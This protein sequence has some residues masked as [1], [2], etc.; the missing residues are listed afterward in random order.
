MRILCDRI[1]FDLDGV[2]A[3]S[4]VVV[5]RH[6]RFWAERRGIAF[7]RVLEVHHGRRT[8]ETISL[9][10]PEL[11]SEAEAAEIEH[12]AADDT[13]GVVAFPGARR[14]L[15]TIPGDRWAI[16]TSGTRRIAT[17][18]IAHLGFPEPRVFVAAEDVTVGKPAP[19]PYLLAAARLGVEARRCLV[20]EDAPAGVEAGLAAGA[21]VVGIA[22]TLPAATLSR[23]TVVIP[24]L[25]DLAVAVRSGQLEVTWTRPEGT[26]PRSVVR[27]PA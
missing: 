9:L 14:L 2:L 24:R 8:V 7:E 18:R 12:V 5:E 22:S 6:L 1:I 17:N 26:N 16:A 10:A 15:E 4:N 13:D 20:V 23:A 19:D 11:D 25:D 3:D 27:R 21:R